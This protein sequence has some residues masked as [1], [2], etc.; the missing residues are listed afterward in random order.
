MG[1][2]K[3]ILMLLGWVA[4][5]FV[6]YWLANRRLR[7][8]KR[9]TLWR[10]L[11]LAYVVLQAAYVVMIGVGSFTEHVPEFRAVLY[12]PVC[13]YV[14]HLF[15]MPGSLLVIAIS[16]GA[17]WI[18]WRAKRGAVLEATVIDASEPLETRLTRREAMA[19]VGVALPPLITAGVGVYGLQGLGNF[20]VQDNTL[21]S[22]TDYTKFSVTAPVDPRLP[23]GGGYQVPGV[24]DLNPDKVGQINNFV[25]L[26][27]DYG[28]WSEN[29]QGVDIT[30]M[31]RPGF[32]PIAG[33]RSRSWNRALAGITPAARPLHRAHIIVIGALGRC[34]HA[35]RRDKVR[36]VRHPRHSPVL[37]M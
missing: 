28:K 29:W 8:F 32:P 11:L 25:T 15:V 27:S 13:A 7:T 33:A 14:W 10:R 6:W 17:R 4:G 2:L 23:G 22:A 3:W 19:A 1:L 20:R 37:A 5:D 9:A 16:A 26:A 18:R 36:A 31:G 12:W 21:V 30:L 24:Y 34:G 35:H